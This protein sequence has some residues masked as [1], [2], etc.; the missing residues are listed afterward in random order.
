MRYGSVFYLVIFS[1]GCASTENIFYESNNN[2]S[3]QEG[4]VYFTND[5]IATGYISVKLQGGNTNSKTISFR[6]KPYTKPQAIPLQNIVAIKCNNQ[7]NVL[8]TIRISETL[9]PVQRFLK[10]L[11]PIN[12]TIALYEYNQYHQNLNSENNFPTSTI[13]YYVQI[14]NMNKGLLEQINS[15]KFIPNFDEKVSRWFT[16]CPSL[17]SKIKNKEPGYFYSLLVDN[18]QKR[19]AIWEN[20]ITEY[21][22]CLK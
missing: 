16:N 9:K 17:A 21:L 20:I 12:D 13:E 18:Q 14:P 7:Y 22:A 4:V 8:K 10:L 2:F 15:K 5:S 1:A 6:A 3:Q 11:T 19:K